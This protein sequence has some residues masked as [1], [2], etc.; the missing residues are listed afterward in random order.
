MFVIH[1]ADRLSIAEFSQSELVDFPVWVLLQR[2]LKVDPFTTHDDGFEYLQS[3]DITAES[4]STWFYDCVAFA[5][6]ASRLKRE[7][8]SALIVERVNQLNYVPFVH[9][10]LAV[11]ES[12]IERM[13]HEILGPYYDAIA[14]MTPDLDASK[15]SDRLDIASPVDLWQGSEQTK[16]TLLEQWSKYI[17]RPYYRVHHAADLHRLL[18]RRSSVS[19]ALTAKFQAVL[20]DQARFLMFN[21]VNYPSDVFTVIGSSIVIGLNVD[22]PFSIEVVEKLLTASAA[23]FVKRDRLYPLSA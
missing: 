6:T 20:E 23:A 8:K 12:S 1:V 18:T 22:R 5:H 10:G 21:F 9:N 16:N 2:G 15:S 14:R 11:Y 3:L 7:G 19:K 13:P 4:W 17:A